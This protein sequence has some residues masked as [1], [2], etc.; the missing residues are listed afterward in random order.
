MAGSLELSVF[1]ISSREQ[2]RYDIQIRS[3]NSGEAGKTGE[4]SLPGY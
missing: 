2:D 4:D 1:A 3:D